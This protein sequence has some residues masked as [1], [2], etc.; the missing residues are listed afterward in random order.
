MHE[1]TFQ[2]INLRATMESI[3]FEDFPSSFNSLSTLYRTY[4]SSFDHVEKFYN[5]PFKSVASQ[6]HLL[7]E[8]GRRPVD[9]SQIAAILEEQQIR[10]GTGKVAEAHSLLLQQDTTFAIVTGQQVGILGGPLYTIY[11]IITALK[12][13][14]I[15]NDKLPSYNFVPVFYLEAEDHDYDEISTV[16]LI[17]SKNELQSI[18]Y[19]PE[20]KPI[21][22][23]PGPVGSIVFDNEI[24]TFLNGIE[25]NLQPSDFRAPVM[26]Q[27]RASYRSGVD[28]ATAFAKYINDLLPNSGLIILDPR[29]LELKKLIKP[30]IQ[31]ELQTHPKT[32]EIVIRWSAALEETY[33]AQAKPRAINLFF[34]HRGGRYLIEPRESGYGLKGARQRFSDDEMLSLVENSPELFSPNVL[35]RPIVQDYLLPTFAYVGGPSEIAYFAQLKDV[36]K[37]F[38]VTMPI[39]YPRASATVIEEKVQRTIE[40]FDI[41]PFDFFIDLQLLLKNVTA[42]L[43]D[44]K[45]EDVFEKTNQKIDESLKEL[46]Y[47]LQTVDPTLTGSFDNARKKI[48][49]QVNRLKE[50]SYEAQRK[51]FSTA[52]RQL[53][54]AALHVAPNGT[55]Q[56]RTY[57]LFQYCN[58]YSMDFVKWLYEQIDIENFDHQLLMR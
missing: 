23:N 12:L 27:L 25:T 9:R 40:K 43:S 42:K 39:I 58:K 29:D 38:N 41:S 37:H 13:A 52:M 19:F 14:E 49:Y 2:K 46:R 34:Q 15:L 21:E 6:A 1:H 48:E 17:N 16:S 5:A 7:D 35:L 10:F 11:K 4:I 54:K 47:A 55:F 28:F 33:H 22:K 3:A 20:G 24:E 30:V 50:K 26:D 45:I 57:P 18:Q 32:S 56:E 36:Y 51:N 8:I 44:V 53:E 31:K